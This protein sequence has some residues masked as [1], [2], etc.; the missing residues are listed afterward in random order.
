MEDKIDKFSHGWRKSTIADLIEKSNDFTDGNWVL[1]KDYEG[2]REVRLL[3]LADVGDGYFVD[4]SNKWLSNNKAEELNGKFLHAGDVLISRLGDPLAK[5]CIVPDL[6]YKI[7]TSVDVAI[8]RQNDA[9]YNNHYISYFFNSPLAKEEVNRLSAGSTRRRISRKNLEKIKI[10]LPPI[11]EQQKIIQK[12]DVLFE[13]ID[14]AVGLIEESLNELDNLL[15]F[16]MDSLFKKLAKKY[17]EITVEDVAMVGTGVTPLKGKS[18]YYT[19]GSVNWI[20]SKATNNEYVTQASDLLT[21]EALAECRLKMFPVG[22]IVVAM[23]GQ[24]KTMG[25]VSELR[26]ETTI[27]Q[28][29]AAIQPD[30]SRVLTRYLKFF[31]KKSYIDL[32]KKASGGTQPNL[33]LTIIKKIAFPLPSI[34]EQKRIIDKLTSLYKCVELEGNILNSQLEDLENL[35]SSILNYAFNGKLVTQEVTVKSSQKKTFALLQGIGAIIEGYGKT[36]YRFGEMVTAKYAFLLQ[37]VFNVPLGIQFKNQSFG[38]YDSSIKKA[39]YAGIK[40]QYFAKDQ[41]GGLVLCNKANRLLDTK[42]ELVQ[43]VRDGMDKLAKHL[44]NATGKKVELLA[45]VCKSILDT[46]STDFAV[47]KSHFQN[48]ETPEQELNTKADKFSDE[49]IQRCIN[50]ILKEGWDKKILYKK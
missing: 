45:T 28:A 35:K 7:L 43:Q 39:V 13:K 24:G 2:K 11:A 1:K 3:Q 46:N 26:I 38:P 22:T 34:T 33:N 36:K 30:E 49:E 29:L 14:V 20:T 5:S 12:L 40:Q 10:P 41:H 4:K 32:R 25:Q 37:H 8:L 21:K 42:Y 27:N 9:K 16:E 19:N 31:L 17:P 15:V 18:K 50:F 6:P 44:K 23:Y 47:I 48:W